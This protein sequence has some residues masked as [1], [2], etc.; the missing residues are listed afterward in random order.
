MK[1]ALALSTIFTLTFLLGSSPALALDPSLEIS[2]YAHTSWT[3]RDGFSMG[4]IYAMAQTPDGYLWFGTEFGLFRFDGA[5]S[6]RWQPPAGQSLP[7]K[8]INSLLVTRDG[9]LWIGTFSGLVTWSAGKLTWRPEPGSGDSLFHPSMRIAKEQ[10]GPALW[11]STA[12]SAQFEAK[13]PS[14]MVRTALSAEPFG[15]CMRTAPEISGPVRNPG[16]GD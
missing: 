15:L 2:Q 8:N 10:C 1:A 6:T 16:F 7:D 4:N 14:V 13:A 3:V 9:T 11:W 5:R 12:V